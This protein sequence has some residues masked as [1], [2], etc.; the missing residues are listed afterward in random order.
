MT[1]PQMDGLTDGPTDGQTSLF[2]CEDAFENDD[3]S[4]KVNMYIKSLK[5]MA[6]WE[7]NKTNLVEKRGKRQRNSEE[8]A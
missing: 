7:I 6:I 2:R 4:R 1:D 5:V 8:T 3:E